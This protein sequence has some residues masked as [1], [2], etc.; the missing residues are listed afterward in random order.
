MFSGRKAQ[1]RL[2]LYVALGLS[3]G[4]GLLPAQDAY[5]AQTHDYTETKT[6]INGLEG[7]DKTHFN[8]DNNITLGIDGGPTDKPF[9]TW[10]TISGG[11]KKNATE[12]V[13]NNTLTIHGLEVSNGG[14]QSMIYG[15]ISG[16]GA[17]ANN[18]VFFNNGLSKDPIY[19]GFNGATATKAVTGNSVTVAGGT[20]EGDV[21]GG[22]T[23]GKGAVTGNSVTIKGGSLGDEAAGGVISNSASSA[24]A[25]D[26]TLTISGGAF[27][28]SGGT[29]VFG[30]YN[31]GSAKPSTTLLTSATVRMPWRR[32]SISRA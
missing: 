5:A 31:A 21:F 9:S 23:T 10:G 13:S 6:S 11:G 32:G 27:T 2:A 16:T 15:G 20:V 18:R 3:A 28:K 1:R 7:S 4:G 30:A 25:A 26:N 12:D 8:S 22:Y 29:N 14:G 19:G 17:V 24:N